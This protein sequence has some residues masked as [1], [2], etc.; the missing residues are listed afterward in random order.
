[1]CPTLDT[2]LR[3]VTPT[4]A[5]APGGSAQPTLQCE[6]SWYTFLGKILHIWLD[7]ER[8]L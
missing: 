5:W 7:Y 8:G 2:K 4:L 3:G 1:M 6:G